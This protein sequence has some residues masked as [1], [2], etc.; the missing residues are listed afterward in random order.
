MYRMSCDDAAHQ[1]ERP[2]QRDLILLWEE[3][4]TISASQEET[5]LGNTWVFYWSRRLRTARKAVLC[6]SIL[7]TLRASYTETPGRHR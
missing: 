4:H 6:K 7:L 5:P 2:P 3:T 1:W